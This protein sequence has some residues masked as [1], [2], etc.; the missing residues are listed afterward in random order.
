MK[1]ISSIQCKSKLKRQLPKRREPSQHQQTQNNLN[2]SPDDN[3]ESSSILNSFLHNDSKKINLSSMN[4][5]IYKGKTE[6]HRFDSD[7][8]SLFNISTVNWRNIRLN[9][10]MILC[11][12]FHWG[13]IILSSSCCW[14]SKSFYTYGYLERI[15]VRTTKQRHG[16]AV[17]RRH[18]LDRNAGIDKYS[19]WNI[20]R[21]SSFLSPIID[22]DNLRKLRSRSIQK[23]TV[24]IPQVRVLQQQEDINT[25]IQGP[26]GEYNVTPAPMSIKPISFPTYVVP[27]YFPP[28]YTAPSPPSPSISPPTSNWNA[29]PPS[30]IY[31]PVKP[32]FK[33][34]SSD[35]EG[36]AV[37]KQTIIRQPAPYTNSS[38]VAPAPMPQ[39]N[40]NIY[41]PSASTLLRSDQ[42]VTSDPEYDI[43]VEK[44][45]TTND[46][47]E[48]SL[49]AT[50]IIEQT[51]SP[52][53]RIVASAPTWNRSSD[54]RTN[55]SM[56]WT[57]VDVPIQFFLTLPRSNQS[58]R[59]ILKSISDNKRKMDSLPN[60]IRSS[61]FHLLGGFGTPEN[62][63]KS[64]LSSKIQR[65]LQTTQSVLTSV[66]EILA[67]YVTD[68][69]GEAIQDPTEVKLESVKLTAFRLGDRQ[70]RK[71]ESRQFVRILV[72]SDSDSDVNLK[73]TGVA[74]YQINAT[75]ISKDAFLTNSNKVVAN[76]VGDEGVLQQV[77]VDA[78]FGT[79]NA[80]ADAA[81]EQ[82][83]PSS[84][85]KPT[86]TEIVIGFVLL[87][88]TLISLLFWAAVLLKKYKKRQRRKRLAALRK[89]SV[90]IGGSSL[91]I[92]RANSERAALPKLVP[93]MSNG[94]ANPLMTQPTPTLTVL[95]LNHNGNND[96][97][98]DSEMY[99]DN[100]RINGA[101]VSEQAATEDDDGSQFAR[102]LQKAAT[103]D[104]ERQRE[105]AARKTSYLHQSTPSSLSSYTGFLL[106]TPTI[107]D[108]DL[109]NTSFPYGDENL[110]ST[111]SPN[112]ISFN[113]A[114]ENIV[115]LSVD[116]ISAANRSGFGL[117]ENTLGNTSSS[118]NHMAINFTP[119]GDFDNEI[120]ANQVSTRA[121]DPDPLKS[122]VKSPLHR[123][124]SKATS[125]EPRLSQANKQSKVPTVPT[126]SYRFSVAAAAEAI[127]RSTAGLHLDDES[128]DGSATM[129]DTELAMMPSDIADN[130]N[131]ESD[132]DDSESVQLTRSMIKE[133]NDIAQYV[134]S[135]KSLKESRISVMPEQLEEIRQPSPRSSAVRNVEHE[136]DISAPLESASRFRNTKVSEGS[137]S[138]GQK[139]DVLSPYSLAS[140]GTSNSALMSYDAFQDDDE[141]DEE[142]Y[143]VVAS[144]TNEDDQSQRLG[145]GRFTVEKPLLN[146]NLLSLGAANISVSQGYKSDN[147]GSLPE[148]LELE[149]SK[150]V[151]VLLDK[152]NPV[153]LSI[154]AKPSTRTGIPTRKSKPM[155]DKNM[156]VGG[157]VANELAKKPLSQE[158]NL[159]LSEEAKQKSVDPV[160]PRTAA[161]SRVVRS[162]NGIFNNI[163]SM[164][165]SKKTPPIIPPSDSVSISS[166]F[167]F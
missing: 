72:R 51:R 156:I 149:N 162:K 2:E 77:L 15:P 146:E 19:H 58:D 44:V 125:N 52:S 165:D 111:R 108:P 74:E 89:N 75:A 147:L 145:I 1:G 138:P 127:M 11:T 80:F 159:P 87:A 14:S 124:S 28:S 122:Q 139:D 40:A 107:V 65:N 9:T 45:P 23:R 103:V 35:V 113:M 55:Y 88:A 70:N 163:V 63:N 46:S 135:Y 106:G 12:V 86:V 154:K 105:Q 118:R 92:C 104:M 152:E 91:S 83:Q 133:V 136:H 90:T 143:I 151:D 158:T 3:T 164:F 26:T 17:R 100:S 53:V 167:P 82:D 160:T 112:N 56:S 121:W 166:F 69:L 62:Q 49:D 96:S 109:Q 73:V 93:S 68:I 132:D 33:P 153:P 22:F 141:S 47:I 81:T 66:E 85:A 155:S 31:V 114:T 60:T 78:D 98:D 16:V 140:A 43:P 8:M 137:F 5:K 99:Y 119:Y 95:S 27:T 128:S 18:D 150:D 117:E 32:T 79:A 37:W 39:P 130:K 123:D 142:D 21:V 10:K 144:C 7:T 41:T 148:Q 94:S 59:R 84:L 48:P 134:E 34:N 64:W 61:L 116:D 161:A 54:I 115:E 50:K 42:P 101:S 25:S 67:E 102:E 97:D 4:Q 126:D 20:E 6:K 36:T 129:S 30:S 71:L 131:I 157:D 29:N 76:A 38:P 120:E 13:L 24:I 57:K 110:M